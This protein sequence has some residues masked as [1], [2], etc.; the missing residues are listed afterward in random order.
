MCGFFCCFTFFIDFN[1][2]YVC[3]ALVFIVYLYVSSAILWFKI[4]KIKI[5]AEC[6]VVIWNFNNS[7][8]NIKTDEKQKSEYYISSW[9]VLSQFPTWYV[10]LLYFLLYLLVTQITHF[11]E[12]TSTFHW[13]RSNSRF[14]YINSPKVSKCNFFL[15]FLT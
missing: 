4:E 1:Q 8:F 6:V 7:T 9:Y 15:W 12:M 3:S 14:W 2:F 13:F 5:D 10:L 11:Y